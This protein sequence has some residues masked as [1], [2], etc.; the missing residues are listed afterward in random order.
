MSEEYEVE[1]IGVEVDAQPIELY[2]VLKIANAVSGG[3]E[4][5]FAISEAT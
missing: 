4:A 2:K 1:A 5:K 3:G